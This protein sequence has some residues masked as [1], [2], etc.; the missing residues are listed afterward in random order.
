MSNQLAKKQANTWEDIVSQCQPDFNQIAVTHKLVQWKA[1]S[2]FALQSLQKNKG[3]AECVPYTV[4]NAIINIAAVGL[5]LN[6]ADG[7]AYLV[8]EYNTQTKQKEC[9]LRISFK[10]LMKVATDSG[11]IQWVKADI[12][13]ENDVFE[14]NG[15]S[16]PPTHKVANPFNTEAR[17]TTIGVYCTAKLYTGEYLTDIMS[18][19]EI[20]QVRKCA[21]FDAVWAQW[22]DEMAKKAII[23]RASKQWPKTEQHSRLN[24]AISVID[25]AE[26]S[27][28]GYLLYT[29]EQQEAFDNAVENEDAMAYLGVT[30]DLQ[31]EVYRALFDA[32]KERL[33]ESKGMTERSALMNNL[34]SQG[35]ELFRAAV[36]D[37][38]DQADDGNLE[39]VEE[40]FAEFEVHGLKD[41]LK[42]AFNEE[43]AELLKKLKNKGNLEWIRDFDGEAE[44]E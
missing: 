20:M 2:Q 27:D 31:D 21:K 12:V 30:H 28:E 13:K 6:P 33:R 5:T 4:K 43:E 15:I 10:G 1:E 9:E 41:K 35:H 14:T 11:A 17:G 36:T 3:L 34:N 40:I 7:Y 25:E 44:S 29:P 24:T 42:R 18:I 38:L 32:N 22:F 19:S 39:A 26:G 8:P 23:K 37:I 16:A